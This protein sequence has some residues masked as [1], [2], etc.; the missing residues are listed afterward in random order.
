MEWLTYEWWWIGTSGTRPITASSAIWTRDPG[1]EYLES[2]VGALR[3][4][5]VRTCAMMKGKGTST[6][7]RALENLRAARPT[8]A[9]RNCE[10]D[11]KYDQ[12]AACKGGYPSIPSE[13]QE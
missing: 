8:S 11:V 2:M 6:T 12:Q 7:R 3:E 4:R 9:P 10:R 13:S 1:C 5:R